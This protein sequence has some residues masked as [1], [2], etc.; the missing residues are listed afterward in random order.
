MLLSGV[1]RPSTSSYASLVVLIKKNDGSW[2]F[3]M[4]FR[5]LNAIIVQDKYSIPLIDELINELQGAHCLTRL[6]LKAGN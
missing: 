5:K 2:Q 1:I 4:D 6:D 3:C